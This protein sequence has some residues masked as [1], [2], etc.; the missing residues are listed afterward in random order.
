MLNKFGEL[1]E[2]TP[3]NVQNASSVL[4]DPA[5]DE[6]FRKFAGE[7]RRIAPKADDF[8][9]FSAVIITAAEAAAYNTDGSSKVDR[10]GEPVKVG[11][12]IDKRGSWK[13]VSSDPSIKAYKNNNGDIFP[14][15]ELLKAHALW[16]GRPLCVDHRSSS[17]D[18]I[19]GVILDTYYDRKHKHVIALC[20]LDKVAYPELARGVS[21][22][23]KTSVS[24]G[25]AVAKAICYDCGNVASTEP[26][27]C[28]H[29]RTKST[30]GEINTGLQPIELSLVASPADPQA[31]IRTIIAA[32]NT[33]NNSLSTQ[34]QEI[35]KLSDASN[36]SPEQRRKIEDLETDLKKANDKLAELKSL[37]DDNAPEGTST[38][39]YGQSSGRYN[40][41]ADVTNVSSTIL[42]VPQRMNVASDNST[43]NGNND[44]FMGELKNLRLSIEARL[45]NMEQ[46]LVLLHNKED[47][48]ADN[49]SMSK[50]AYFQ[51]A[52]GVNE[53][54]PH[55]V[56][57]PIDPLNEK[58]R[59]EDKHMNGEPPFPG[60]GDVDG[61]HP[62]PSSADQKDELERKKLLLRAEEEERAMRRAA[63]LQKAKENIMKQ[64]EAYFQ[65]GG[66]VNEPTPH[67]VKYPIDPLDVKDREKEDKQ[68]VGQKPFPGVG[69]VDGLHPSP[70]SADEKDELKRK[71]LLQ[72][73]SLKARFVR[74]G[75]ADGTDNLGQSA[76]HV[77]AKSDEGEKL[78][79]TAS[80][81]E[82]TGG[83]ADALFDVVATKEFGSKLIGKIRTDGLS[84][85][86]SL[87]KKAQANVGPGSN[88]GAADMGGPGAVPPMDAAPP[89]DAAP[90]GEDKGGAGDTKETALKLAEE[91]RDK[92]SDLLEAVRGLTGEKSEMGDMEEGLEAL[93]KAASATLRPLTNMRKQLND[94]LISGMKKSIAELNEHAEELELIAS[95][96]DS[97]TSLDKEYVNTVI[98]EAFV[99]ANKALED[100]NGLKNAHAK[101]IS[102]TAGLVK[103][104]EEAGLDV[105]NAD[106]ENDARKAKKSKK[107]EDSEDESSADDEN[108]ARK[109]KKST[110]STDDEDDCMADDSSEDSEDESSADDENDARKAKKSKKSEDSE[111]ESSADDDE[112]DARKA[113]KSK[114]SEDSEDESSADDEN[115]AIIDDLAADFEDDALVHD[116]NAHDH[117]DHD[118]DLDTE[119]D[120]DLDSLELPSDGALDHNDVMM[121]VD[122][123]SLANHK[124]RL[125]ASDEPDLTTK[126]GRAAYRA[127]LANDATGKQE[128]GEVESAEKIKCAPVMDDANRLAD[129]QTK[130]DT[131]PSDSLGLVETKPERLKVMLEVARMPP[132]VRK[133]AERLHQFIVEGKVK[134]SDLDALIAQGLDPEVVKYWRQYWGEA[135]KEGSEFGKMLT[136]ETFKAKMAEEMTGYKVKLGR[137]YEVASDMVRRGLLADDRTA[138]SAQVEEIMKWNDDAFDSMKRVI[139]K[140]APVAIKKEASV[141]M[142]G[143][144]GSGDNFSTSVETDLASELDRA[145]S[146]RKY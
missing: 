27:F 51:G 36:L 34:E 133:E 74:V 145:F 124:V 77:Y 61:M 94:A 26:E 72:R 71:Q 97:G 28:T 66:G 146:S 100:A 107:S 118:T 144:I 18:A 41:P 3:A 65:G 86:A 56:K 115:S 99:D 91:V 35:Q 73:A 68:M 105:S 85:A 119:E 19:R 8:L 125:D 69:D 75:N 7:L 70:L 127:K 129:G 79:F 128:N 52:G 6:R 104:A 10:Y 1:I 121:D 93:P 23:Y 81:D 87:Y 2:L 92:A 16:R 140:H 59:S 30:Y 17:V 76:W 113:K 44:T 11:W 80:V 138:V 64:K 29:M 60:V 98:D 103:R 42:N 5:V 89:A 49:S 90:A 24:M 50:E 14:E 111:D 21:T 39:P 131:K 31:K 15:A 135:G 67:K 122:P 110:K 108:D 9:Y 12:E 46:A 142:V 134:E 22:G 37:M 102:G 45:S 54:A 112:N 62:S 106:D 101:Y 32:A 48:M 116:L 96:V 38:A 40:D 136:T 47:I 4:A 82:I 120:L 88:P 25:T 83:R 123:G 33:L 139:A 117:M 137:A 58:A 141:P 55:K 43:N 63:A 57:Y 84:K 53:P 13:W 114:K 78:V 109:A 95:V 143:L 126:E 132:K 130:L 20:A